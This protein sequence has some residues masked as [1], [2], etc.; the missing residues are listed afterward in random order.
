MT[1]STPQA[2]AHPTPHA[3]RPAPAPSPATVRAT[4]QPLDGIHD[5]PVEE[6]IARYRAL[7]DDLAT[8]L[9]TEGE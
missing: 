3:P 6:Q 1:E 7:H 2:P 5:L 8:Q 4:L 9:A